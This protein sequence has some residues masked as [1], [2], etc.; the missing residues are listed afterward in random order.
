MADGV[1]RWADM[2]HKHSTPIR[3]L[4]IIMDAPVGFHRGLPASPVEVV[5][6]AYARVQ[7]NTGAAAASDS[8][9][10]A[11]IL[12]ANSAQLN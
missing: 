4:P 11:P 6:Q 7:Q 3:Y 8:W 5:D 1:I 12:L 9:R 2:R 10:I